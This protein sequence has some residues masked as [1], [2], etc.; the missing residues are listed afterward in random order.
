MNDKSRQKSGLHVVIMVRAFCC[1]QYWTSE[2]EP[3]NLV[4]GNIIQ[5]KALYFANRTQI[6]RWVK[7][8]M[9]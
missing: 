8:L 1:E 3:Y 5:S 2:E 7:K 9:K 4:F 6:N